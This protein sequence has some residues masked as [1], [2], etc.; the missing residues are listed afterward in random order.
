MN[1]HIEFISILYYIAETKSKANK[2]E[3]LKLVQESKKAQA[4]AYAPGTFDNLSYQ[5]VRFLC[6]CEKHEMT[7]LP[8]EPQVL[9]CY[10]QW[11]ANTVKAHAT[12]V[13]YL[14]G[15]KTL[16]KLLNYST[17]SFS[18]HNFKLTIRGLRRTCTHQ[19][20]QAE[21]MT[22]SLLSQIHT[23]LDWGQE[24]DRV[25]WA[26]SLVA[27]FLLFRKS[28]LVPD[29]KFGFDINK[30]LSWGNVQFRTG[31]ALVNIR[32]S[33]TNQFREELIQFPLPEIQGSVLCPIAALK[34]I[35]PM[36]KQRSTVFGYRTDPHILMP[37]L[38]V[39]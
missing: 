12:M 19:P 25:F 34:N 33:K 1:L 9:C 35:A 6:F 30:Q 14:S 37:C 8:V 26:C 29:K 13:A 27:F 15:V 22:L 32:W 24:K 4:Q 5:W 31:G 2:E 39:S 38:T 36:N 11:T 17:E 20:Q 28:N 3:W 7:A 10:A 16:H 23:T 21:P 18:N